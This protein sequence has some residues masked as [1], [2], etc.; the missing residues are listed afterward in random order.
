MNAAR[1][2]GLAVRLEM[3]QQ[4]D[5]ELVEAAVNRQAP[6]VST[7]GPYRS[8]EIELLAD[9]S[10]FAILA[11][12][13]SYGGTALAG[14]ARALIDYGALIA[15]GSGLNRS[16]DRRPA[17][18]WMVIQKA[19]EVLGLSLAEAI[20][21]ATVN[22]AWAL[23]VGPQSGSLEYG[24]RADLILLNASDYRD[25]ALLAGT[26][27][28]HSMIKRGVVLFKEDFPGWPREPD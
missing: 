8:P 3:P 13:N 2:L 6:S 11:A 26:N 27:L 15:L 14:S 10:T 24:K 12:A 5:V 9:S 16:A 17:R 1:S 7:T 20:S 18:A 19:C 23:G 22:A 4:H 25:I 21:A 28:V